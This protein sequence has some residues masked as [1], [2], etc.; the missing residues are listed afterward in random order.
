SGKEF[1]T[2]ILADRRSVSASRLQE[3]QKK[4]T[5]A[6]EICSGKACVY[7]TG[8]FGRGDASEYSDLDLFIVGRSHFDETGKEVRHLTSLN[9]TLVKAE[10]IEASREL[11]FPDFSGDGEYLEHYTIDELVKTTGK[12]EDDAA[13]TFTARLLLILESRYLIG[14]DVYEEVINAAIDQY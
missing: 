14:E 11:R 9:E 1:M 10:L 2:N 4:L 7:A 3:F 6:K 5:R 13:N 12:P 8:S